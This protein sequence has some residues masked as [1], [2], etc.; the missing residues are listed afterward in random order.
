MFYV[1]MHSVLVNCLVGFKPSQEGMMRIIGC[2]RKRFRRLL[3]MPVQTANL[4]AFGSFCSHCPHSP[5]HDKSNRG[6]AEIHP[7]TSA[8]TD[9]ISV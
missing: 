2:I 1:Y 7:N 5:R 8:G 3:E 4:L 6:Q 9:V